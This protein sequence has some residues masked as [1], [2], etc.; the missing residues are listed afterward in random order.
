[1][2]SVPDIDDFWLCRRCGEVYGP[3]EYLMPRAVQLCCCTPPKTGL[4]DD[5]PRPPSRVLTLCRC[6]GLVEVKMTSKWSIWFCSPCESRVRALNT[7]AGWSVL[8][9]G[10]HSLMGGVGLRGDAPITEARVTAFTDQL[11]TFFTH[12]AAVEDLGRSTVLVNLADLGVDHDVDLKLTDYLDLVRQSS[13][14]SEDRFA[15]VI[16]LTLDGPTLNCQ[17]RRGLTSSSHTCKRVRPV[18]PR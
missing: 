6:C 13:V 16:A 18:P 3:V 17:S 10:R 1:M 15:R 9:L 5:Y 2:S 14:T 4:V 7:L 8:P 11:R 12:A